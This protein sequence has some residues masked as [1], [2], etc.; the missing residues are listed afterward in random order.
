M[1][2]G[3]NVAE[4]KLTGYALEAEDSATD[5]GDDAL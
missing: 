5:C 3:A 1:S 4:L 2:D